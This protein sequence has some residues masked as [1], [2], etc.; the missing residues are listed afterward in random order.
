[1]SEE[2]SITPHMAN[3]QQLIC[4]GDPA[5]DAPEHCITLAFGG[6]APVEGREYRF[7]LPDDPYLVLYVGWKSWFTQVTGDGAPCEHII[8]APCVDLRVKCSPRVSFMIIK[9][10]AK[11]PLLDRMGEIEMESEREMARVMIN[12]ADRLYPSRPH[13]S[14]LSRRG[15]RLVLPKIKIGEGMVDHWRVF[16]AAKWHTWEVN[17][18]SWDARAADVCASGFDQKMTAKRLAT[19]WRRMRQG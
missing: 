17:G 11:I 3:K 6:V 9:W 1:M 2:L 4:I 5:V 8:C 13:D 15:G 12:L 14:K 16:A 19:E 7:H 10:D 18:D